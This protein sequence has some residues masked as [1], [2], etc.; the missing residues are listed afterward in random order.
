MYLR[1]CINIIPSR[2]ARILVVLQQKSEFNYK[3][4]VAFIFAEHCRTK[5]HSERERAST[6]FTNVGGFVHTDCFIDAKST[7]I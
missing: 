5:P 7:C 1:E 4:M 3:W 6:I 2:R